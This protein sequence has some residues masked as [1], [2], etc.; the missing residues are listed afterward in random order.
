MICT[1]SNIITHC[2]VTMDVTSKVITHCD[3][4]MGIPSNVITHCDVIMRFWYQSHLTGL[5]LIHV[6]PVLID[7]IW[8]SGAWYHVTYL[9]TV[10]IDDIC[11]SL[12]H[13]TIFITQVPGTIG[14]LG[15]VSSVWQWGR[16]FV[17]DT[18][19]RGSRWKAGRLVFYKH[20]NYTV[21]RG[22]HSTWKISNTKVCM[23]A[24]PEIGVYTKTLLKR[25]SSERA[26]SQ[27]FSLAHKY[28]KISSSNL[29]QKSL[30]QVYYM[31]GWYI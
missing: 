12:E 20:I 18:P 21:K 27:T 3:F 2:D 5:V 11:D 23:R 31:C 25:R 7:N 6:N 9:C 10:L 28:L 24:I 4:T 30:L 16:W 8:L 19:I 22:S 13:D 1:H 17:T 26:P 15:I 29:H 14:W